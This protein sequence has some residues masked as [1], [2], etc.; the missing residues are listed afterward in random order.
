MVEDAVS[1]SHLRDKWAELKWPPAEQNLH[2]YFVKAYGPEHLAPFKA[3]QRNF[4]ESM[5]GY[6]VV[7]YLLKVCTCDVCGLMRVVCVCVC[8]YLRRRGMV[9][10]RLGLC[11]LKDRNDGNLLLTRDTCGYM[12]ACT[13]E[14]TR[15]YVFMCK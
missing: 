3:A 13:Y 15:M 6:A 5:A 11:L 14:C 7:C 10:R 2:A 9:G 1:L 8:V 12:C 4:I